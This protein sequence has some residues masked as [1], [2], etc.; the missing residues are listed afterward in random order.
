MP[1]FRLASVSSPCLKYNSCTDQFTDRDSSGWNLNPE[2]L[3]RR[4]RLF[5]ELY[6]HDAWTVSS[7]CGHLR[8]TVTHPHTVYRQRAAT[9]FDDPTYRLPF[10]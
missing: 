3:Q 10:S 2:E 8:S 6:T 9:S 1:A 7:H 4:R 5:W